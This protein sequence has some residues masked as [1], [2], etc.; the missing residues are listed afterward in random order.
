VIVSGAITHGYLGDGGLWLWDD[1][2]WRRGEDD[3]ATRVDPTILQRSSDPRRRPRRGLRGRRRRRRSAALVGRRWPPPRAGVEAAPDSGRDPRRTAGEAENICSG[4]L[5][6]TSSRAGLGPLSD[7]DLDQNYRIR[8]LTRTRI[9]TRTWMSEAIRD[10]PSVNLEHRLR[11]PA[12][13]SEASGPNRDH[14]YCIVN[15]DG[16][17]RTRSRLGPGL[18][19]DSRR[20][21]RRTARQ[22]GALP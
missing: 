18:G 22:A 12:S 16:R 2:G 19:P 7:S 1:G 13:D 3:V 8:T 11:T 14:R 6:R 21:P 20:D 17:G 15:P 5:P 10:G 4:H 9:Q